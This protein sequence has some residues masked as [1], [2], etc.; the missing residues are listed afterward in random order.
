MISLIT[1]EIT[2]CDE[3]GLTTTYSNRMLS[4]CQMSY[5]CQLTSEVTMGHNN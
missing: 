5:V 3:S 1:M 2:C 4:G